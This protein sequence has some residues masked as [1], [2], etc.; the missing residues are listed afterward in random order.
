MS[1]DPAKR[2][3][4]EIRQMHIIDTHEHL[5]NRQMLSDLGF[6]LFSAIELEYLKDSLMAV[7]MAPDLLVQAGFE[8][9]SSYEALIPLLKQTRNTTY[10]RAL[11]QAFRDLHHIEGDELEPRNLKLLSERLN[12]AYAR[13][14][15]YEHVIR[16]EC[17]IRWILRD[18]DFM[19][20]EHD[21]IRPVIR[22][23]NYLMLRH[24]HLLQDWIAKGEPMFSLRVTEHE[25]ADRVKTFDD[26][27]ALMDADF[28]KALAFGAVAIKVGIAY[29]R[30]LQ[31]DKV[32]LDRAAR[33]FGLPDEKT[34]WSDI[35]AFQDFIIFRIIEKAAEHNL[36]VQIHTGLLAGGKNTLANAHPLHLTNLLLEFP[37][38]RFDIFHGGFP[39][40]G[41]LG[42]LAL[43]FP[44]V[45]LDTCWLPLI[46]YE[47]FKSAFREWLSYVPAAKFLWGGDCACAEGTYG[48]ATVVRKALSAVLAES[49]QDGTLDHQSAVDVA[50]AILHDNAK[51]LFGL[52]A[53]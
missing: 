23:D 46:S 9:E 11:F 32:S 19:V 49:V 48:A 17:R 2:L 38:V 36:P 22:M 12:S 20:S 14:D 44:N 39:F 21:F 50:K 26:Y 28:R 27:L 47:A 10:Y 41:E 6:N 37:Q 52:E 53:N 31:F 43:M 15:W 5:V 18:L 33:V 40:T 42:A 29:S 3:Y 35:K 24:R 25:Y 4:D 30:T 45:Y 13:P 51:E 8:P 7:G 1:I 16:D 34:S